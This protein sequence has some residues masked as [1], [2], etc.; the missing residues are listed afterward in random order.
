MFFGDRKMKLEEMVSI[1]MFHIG[2]W[3]TAMLDRNTCLVS[4]YAFLILMAVYKHTVYL[5]IHSK[6]RTS[7]TRPI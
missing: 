5:Y 3:F 6:P 4:T 2:I 1:A 7:L